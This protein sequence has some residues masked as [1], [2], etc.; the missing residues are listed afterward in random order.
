ASIAAVPTSK[1][2]DRD[3]PITDI[4]IIRATLV[5]RKK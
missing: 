5:K 4:M 3:R 2:V 1:G